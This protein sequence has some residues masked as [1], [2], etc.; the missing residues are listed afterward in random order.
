VNGIGWSTCTDPVGSVQVPYWQD[1]VI[2][3][4]WDD[5]GGWFDHVPPFKMQE[6]KKRRVKQGKKS[7]WKD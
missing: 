2:F 7:N 5:W 1:T 3:I 4:L 6:K